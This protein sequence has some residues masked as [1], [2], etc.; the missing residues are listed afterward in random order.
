MRL[1]EIPAVRSG[2]EGA[3]VTAGAPILTGT[4]VLDTSVLL[5]DPESIYAFGGADVV[6]PL[7][8]IEELDNHKGRLDEVGRA[9]RTTARLLEELRSTSAGQ[10]LVEPTPL[11][12]G[13]TLRVVIN[14]LRLDRIREL[15]LDVDK[16]DNRIL[17]AA[18][19]IE[20]PVTLVSADVNLRLKAAAV[21]LRA[22]EYRQVR[23]SFHT[24]A[25]PGWR[26]VAVSARLVDELYE[27]AG[28]GID[29]GVLAPGDL[30]AVRTLATNEFGV[31]GAGQQ[32]ALVRR[33][34]GS[35]RVLPRHAEA[36]GLR[37]RS[38]E[39]R[40]ALDLLMD[41]DV[42]IVGLSGRAGTGKTI[43]AIAAGLEQTFEPGEGH[44]YD[45]IMIIRPLVAVGRQDIG[46]LPGDKSEK[47]EPWFATVE[48]TMTALRDDLDHAK[49][50][51]M[52]EDWVEQGTLSMEAVT[53]L[54]GR[55][56]QRTF[57]VVDEAQNL[58]PLTLK[59][60]LTRLGSGSKV[61]LIGDVSQIDSPFVS[62]RTSAISILADRFAGQE[63]F[64]HLV[65]TQGERSA[66]ADLAAE[67]L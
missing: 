17:A 45:R 43:L 7:K 18:L 31:L 25:H 46:F 34:K 27:A 35:I 38:K 50:R 44:H 37:P 58:E 26:P 62:E 53:F 11:V 33:R 8:V 28:R 36:W 60:I 51:A 40:F 16:A 15:G 57:I 54:R 10:D 2:R 29:D 13:G 65:L 30:E 21:G 14:G 9:A 42:P 49:A 52:L 12:G 55:S 24:E 66:V 39:Q 48:D 67:L 59:T 19:G 64:G 47:L 3:A 32:S 23:S 22:E 20:A 4:F 5:A 61:V 56:L 41:A 1:A 63:L 6:L